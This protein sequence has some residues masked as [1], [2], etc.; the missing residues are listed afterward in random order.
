M[1][2]KKCESSLTENDF[3]SR[4][5]K[6]G[7]RYSSTCKKCTNQGSKERHDPIVRYKKSLP[8]KFGISWEDY[9][10]LYSNQDGL[11]AICKSPIKI[12]GEHINRLETGFVDHDHV[13]GKVRGL[14]CS[15]C[16]LALGL[17][18]DSK[19]VLEAASRYLDESNG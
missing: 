1:I 9:L 14:L 16:N 6:E 18:K 11:C 17:F 19:L 2:C 5:K 3:Y 12:N 13:T 7:L 4:P 8:K 10:D 15:P